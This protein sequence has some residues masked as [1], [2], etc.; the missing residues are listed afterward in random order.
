MPTKRTLITRG[1][2]DWYPAEAIEVFRQMQALRCDWDTPR[3][4]CCAEWMDLQEKLFCLLGLSDA[5][6]WCIPPRR[7]PLGVVYRNEWD[8]RARQRYLDLDALT[9]ASS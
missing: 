3:D 5:E 8:E 6:W 1:P 4:A 9:K 2:R 7:P